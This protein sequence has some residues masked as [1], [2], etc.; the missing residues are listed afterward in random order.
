MTVDDPD[1]RP[2]WLA[3]RTASVRALV[4]AFLGRFFENEITGG[5]PDLRVGVYFLIAFLAM[6]GFVAPVFIASAG[7]PWQPPE[8]WGW[9]L[10]AR[11]LGVDALRLQSLTDKGVYLAV[12]MAVTG[13][14]AAVTWNSVMTDR[15]DAAVLGP[16]PVSGRV[17]VLARLLA[18]ALFVL[19]VS[20]A[21]HT[22]ASASFGMGLSY[23]NTFVFALRGI[24][25]HFVASCAG[26]LFVLLTVT[27]LQGVALTTIGPRLF[28]RL[29]A[30]FQVILVGAIVTALAL[31]PTLSGILRVAVKGG[32]LS[33][34][35]S[36][37][38]LIPPLWFLG[39]YEVVLGTTDPTAHA[40]ASL[41]LRGLGL[42]AV[43]TVVGYALGY[44]RVTRS[45]IETSR[46]SPRAG[47][48]GGT[49]VKILSR[50][51][52]L[53]GVLAFGLHSVV[54]L[55]RQ[56]LILA[57]AIGAGIAWTL[58]GW[59]ALGRDGWFEPNPSVIAI[60][61]SPMVLLLAGLRLAMALPADLNAAWVFEFSLAPA[62]AARVA[63]ER[64]LLG[65][66]VGPIA[67][68]SATAVWSL[69]GWAAGLT[70]LGMT[71]GVGLLV[72]QI[73]LWKLPGI[74]CALAWQPGSFNVRV[75]GPVYILGFAAATT[76]MAWLEGAL[77]SRPAGAIVVV[78]YITAVGLGVRHASIVR[79]ARDLRRRETVADFSGTDAVTTSRRDWTADGHGGPESDAALFR[80]YTRTSRLTGLVESL[81]DL[82]TTFMEPRDLARQLGHDVR[83]AV[84]RLR[85][86]PLF[87]AFAIA[88]IAIGVGATAAVY[89]VTY[90]VLLRPPDIPHIDRVV[91]LYQ[92]DR[93]SYNSMA[94]AWPDYEDFRRRQ[95]SFSDVTAFAPF[96]EIL[97]TDGATQILFGE[98]VDGEFFSFV[99]ASMALGRP[100][101]PA[102]DTPTAPPVVVLSHRLWRTTFAADP[103]IIGRIVRV[104]GQQF[105]IIGVAAPRVRGVTMPNV[106]P[107]QAWVPLSSVT[108][109][110]SSVRKSDRRDDGSLMVRARLADGVTVERA[111]SEFA[112]IGRQLDAEH[113]LNPNDARY[114]RRWTLKPT[115]AVRV[116]EPVAMVAVPLTLIVM[117]TVSVVLVIACSN[118][119]NL[120]LARTLRRRHE[121]AVRLALGASR[122]RLIREEVVETSLLAAAGAT[123][124]LLVAK[125]TTTYLRTDLSLRL[126]SG[127]NAEISPEITPGVVG[128]LLLATF[129]TLVVAGAWPAWRLTQLHA[130]QAM[131]AGSS[132][133]S[134]GGWR[135]RQLL[136]GLQ[137]AGS[138]VLLVLATLFAG[139]LVA[140]MARNPGFDTATLVV[141]N[142]ELAGETAAP[143]LPTD[144][145]ARLET[146]LRAQPG[147]ASVAFTSAL[148]TGT[149]GLVFAVPS[150]RSHDK[151]ARSVARIDATPGIFET[152]GVRLA[153][154]R[155]FAPDRATAREVVLSRAA[156]QQV[157]G[158]HEVVGRQVFLDRRDPVPWTV[159]GIAENTDVGTI[160]RDDVGLVYTAFETDRPRPRLLMVVAV[161][162][163]PSPL[164]GRI[165][166]LVRQI[167]PDVAVIEATT[168]D[169]AAGMAPGLTLFVA[170]LSGLLSAIAFVLA[171][172]GL[173]SVLSARV[174][175]RTREIGIR[176]AL[177]ATRSGVLRMVLADGMRPVAEGLA[178]GAVAA[179]ALRL[180]ARAFSPAYVPEWTWLVVAVPALLLVS[181]A[182]ACYLPAR[183][184]TT[185]EPARTLRDG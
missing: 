107:S 84:R 36:D 59:I 89:A 14:I 6:P 52:A 27:G 180:S 49:F 93:G 135:G 9:E 142:L 28:T 165:A 147:V 141:G 102:D 13:V 126:F 96:G 158:G 86:R 82:R 162:G 169:V 45:A 11:R 109:L 3:R 19:G 128:V 97:A 106:R 113:P 78:T 174:L 85:T 33:A 95:T 138:V 46:R 185:I 124:A 64:L 87:A 17:V 178:I 22:L 156:A 58:P 26:T 65:I 61:Y 8:T 159:V 81:R 157:F 83:M 54:R 98:A 123:G 134:G 76:G 4:P 50:D 63:A 72:A 75:M 73:L 105:E 130:R 166:E 69:W 104:G 31:L 91:N 7:V 77:M 173:F 80:S 66:G 144:L 117:A 21:M 181:G 35:N 12:A 53:R 168:G 131:A 100:L 51:S 127:V 114:I 39:L 41:A 140:R 70:H 112:A 2:S 15:K 60:A 132:T 151:D 148:P 149:S 25:A 68:L 94:L 177:G 55:E 120:N 1:D 44:A 182:A 92:Q 118:L 38:V 183:H 143:G 115:A 121:V 150:D 20:A 170:T 37:A 155:A 171:I 48:I 110:L 30:F 152:L 154:G 160:G 137:V 153:I 122:A 133:V 108:T 62:R 18:L 56:R 164:A 175:D 47:W 32:G 116:F 111:L 23:R 57:S 176:L 172:A 24:A 67:V 71:S 34:L 129:T 10:L 179:T 43:A 74:P 184:A 5:G 103:Q 16:L 146:R 101:Q 139:Q 145:L 99:G 29:S 136:V 167:E 42:A 161:T 125:L 88:T 163:D 119:A 90:A 40:L 79:A